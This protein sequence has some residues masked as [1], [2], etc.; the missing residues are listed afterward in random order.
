MGGTA[1]DRL[2]INDEGPGVGNVSLSGSNVRYDFGGGPI[3]IGTFAGGT[4]GGDPLVVTFNA[5]S[6]VTSAQAVMRNIAYQNVGVDPDTDARMVRFVLTD[7]DGGT[8]NTATETINVSG[9][10]ILV[11]T[12]IADLA[13]APVATSIDA[14]LADRGGDGGDLTA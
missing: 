6:D 8:S 14:L 1:N 9:D 4:S 7:G 13:D 3:V 12:T 2:T 5:S 11:V 10:N